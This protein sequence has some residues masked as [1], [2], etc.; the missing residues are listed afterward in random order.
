MTRRPTRYEFL[1][2]L[3]LVVLTSMDLQ[4]AP[5]ATLVFREAA[6]QRMIRHFAPMPFPNEGSP[7]AIM[8]DI[9]FCG[10]EGDTAR[11][12]ALLVP[13]RAEATRWA[14]TLRAEDCRGPISTVTQRLSQKAPTGTIVE[15]T[16]KWHV[17]AVRFL[18]KSA[19]QVTASGVDVSS[20]VNKEPFSPLPTRDLIPA[21]AQTGS[22][23]ARLSF[24]ADELVV[25]LQEG[26]SAF[27]SSHT[28]GVTA[29]PTDDTLAAITF[30]FL[31]RF[32]ASRTEGGSIKTSEGEQ[33]IDAKNFRIQAPD[34]IGQ[35]RLT[36]TVSN[37]NLG[38]AVAVVTL[39]GTDLT[40]SNIQLN[41]S[42]EGC[43]PLKTKERLDCHVKNSLRRKIAAGLAMGLMK[44]VGGNPFRPFGPRDA[45]PIRLGN[46]NL[47]LRASPTRSWA[48]ASILGF[49][50]QTTLDVEP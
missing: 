8:T 19:H 43:A 11:A 9:I 45:L 18:V 16:A 2:V 26:D 22:V 39:S 40:Y 41:A 38:S 25:D 5:V 48:D 34:E 42:Q 46:R 23:S 35:T 4:A 33:K 1:V 21:T 17:A 32:L 7:R 15:F 30:A 13:H 50:A 3:G 29:T 10:G 37:D 14:G 49:S 28:V 27:G 12:L 20:L 47:K 24:R 6:V 44:R 31:N 36:A